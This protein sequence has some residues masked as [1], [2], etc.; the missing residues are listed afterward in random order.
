LLPSSAA[1]VA[2]AP[3]LAL[4]GTHAA[5]LTANIKSI[6]G[7]S[8]EADG[9]V[10]GW[11][12]TQAD[13]NTKIDQAKAGV[14]AMAIQ[15]GTALIPSVLSVLADG[16]QWTTWLTEH[17][18]VTWTIVGALGAFATAAIAVKVASIASATATG[19]WTVA[20][21]LGTA[22]M[23]LFTAAVGTSIG[24]TLALKAMYLG[25]AIATGV[26]TA[27]QWL[28][29]A[30]L[31]ANPIGL[32]VVGIGL[33]VAA[34][35]WVATKTT[36]FQTAWEYS[37]HAIGAVW[38]WL[39]NTVLAPIFRFVMDGLGSIIG[40][41]SNM[42]MALSH[43]PGFGWAKDAAVAMRSA[44]DQAH[45]LANGITDIPDHKDIAIRY[46][47]TVSGNAPATS[48]TGPIL[49]SILHHSSGGLIGGTGTRDTELGVLTPGEFVVRRDGS[50]IADALEHFGAKTVTPVASTS[51]GASSEALLTEVQGL[52]SDVRGLVRSYQTTQRQYA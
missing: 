7:A 44:S 6:S 45:N 37:S 34:I 38:Q 36:W 26:M 10:K 27:A 25:S 39:W 19:V 47:I 29:N 9:H 11:A 33:L 2:W 30:A 42:L 52:R 32:V 50:N 16:K 43:I 4:T 48:G 14:S 41:I 28:L 31:T 12:L 18:T 22:A 5:T 13:F 3:R 40:G 23:W 24:E 8:T 17:T 15:I 1:L 21:S 35:I 51:S 49:Q 20:T 46:S